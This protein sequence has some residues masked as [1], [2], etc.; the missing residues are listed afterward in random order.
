MLT[1]C[2]P[3]QTVLSLVLTASD[4]AAQPSK[5]LGCFGSFLEMGTLIES[6]SCVSWVLQC[7][8]LLQADAGGNN[9]A[10][11]LKKQSHRA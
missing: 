9:D 3:Q 1:A 10:S 5:K 2:H 4:R 7:I 8:R 11:N 6:V